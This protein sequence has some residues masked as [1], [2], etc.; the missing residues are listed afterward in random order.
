M[1]NNDDDDTE[2]E[3]TN[4]VKPGGSTGRA[5]ACLSQDKDTFQQLNADLFPVVMVIDV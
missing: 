4:A 3:M 5:V 1:P 2:H